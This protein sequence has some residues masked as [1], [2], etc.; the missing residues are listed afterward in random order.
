MKTTAPVDEKHI[1]INNQRQ[2]PPKINLV[3]DQLRKY[4]KLGNIMTNDM[5]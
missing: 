3:E 2:W 4:D 5:H 1:S